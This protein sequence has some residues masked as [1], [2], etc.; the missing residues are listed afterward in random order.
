MT[1]CDDVTLRRYRPADRDAVWRL[2]DRALRDAGT[3]PDDVPGVD[4]LDRVEQ[5]Y[6]RDGEFLVVDVPDGEVVAMGGIR[7]DADGA[8]AEVRRMRVAPDRQRDGLGSL[9]LHGLQRAARDR[10]VE[11]IVLTTA[12]RQTAATRFYPARGYQEMGRRRAGTYELVR[13]EKRL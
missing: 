6:L 4:D 8:T 13:F 9:I 1:G 5:A 3:G 10:G 11:R 7:V 2:H 12:A